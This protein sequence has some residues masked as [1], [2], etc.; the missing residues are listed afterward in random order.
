MLSNI[1]VTIVLKKLSNI[2]TYALLISGVSIELK[3]H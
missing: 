3:Q 1:Y 2:N